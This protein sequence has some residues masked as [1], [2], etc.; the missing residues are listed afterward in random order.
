MNGET[1]DALRALLRTANGANDVSASAPAPRPASGVRNQNQNIPAGE[2]ES[3]VR[4]MKQDI[5]AERP[6]RPAA[7]PQPAQSNSFADFPARQAV[8][9]AQQ[10]FATRPQVPGPA[11]R[12]AAPRTAAPQTRVVDV[13]KVFF[14]PAASP[15]APIQLSAVP[16]PARQFPQQTQQT[17]PVAPRAQPV[18]ASQPAPVP[19]PAPAQFGGNG[20]TF[21]LLDPNNFAAFD[22]QFGGSVPVNPGAS[23][24]GSSVF[25]QPRL[26]QQQPRPQ[27]A[28]SALPAPQFTGHPASGINLQ[29]GAFN[30]QTGK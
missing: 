8:Q 11:P 3:A 28:L 4:E 23:Q 2:I 29:T 5:Q 15:D 25:G 10:R 13:E 18:P 7:A 9:P 17:L 26:V 20:N 27:S 14:Q 12:T 1:S 24:L 30:L 16:V 21:G 22:A 19:T 6:R